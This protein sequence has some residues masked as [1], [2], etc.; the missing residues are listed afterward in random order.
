MGYAILGLG[1]HPQDFCSQPYSNDINRRRQE[2]RFE[3]YNLWSIYSVRQNILIYLRFP[4]KLP[5]S[6]TDEGRPLESSNKYEI[7][8]LAE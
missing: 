2:E 6:G 7:K 8:S 5:E 3:E 1:L 4:G